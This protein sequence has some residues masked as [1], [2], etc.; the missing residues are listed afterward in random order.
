M[1][2]DCLM[3]NIF[4]TITYA[5]KAAPEKEKNVEFFVLPSVSGLVDDYACL[6][7]EKIEDFEQIEE[8]C[9][10]KEKTWNYELQNQCSEQIEKDI[11]F[12][13]GLE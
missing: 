8:K 1:I 3:I 7:Y 2:F 6:E 9:S 10:W 13:T 12:R 11:E 5:T 4:I